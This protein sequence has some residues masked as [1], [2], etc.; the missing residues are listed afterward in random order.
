ML[1]EAFSYFFG[2]SGD[3]I[4]NGDI[5]DIQLHDTGIDRGKIE[6]IIDDG[7]QDRGRCADM[8]EIIALTLVERA[9][10]RRLQQLGKAHDV[11]QRRT[12]LV[13]DMLDEIVLQ[14]IRAL[15]RLILFL[16]R[17]FDPHGIRYIDEGQHGLAAWQGCRG[18]IKDFSGRQLDMT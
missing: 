9:G 6:N 4:G 15:Q 18:K 17:P 10:H 14:F 5:T 12:Q 2:G 1:L 8:V 3:G 16:Q 13:G 11:G 7:Q